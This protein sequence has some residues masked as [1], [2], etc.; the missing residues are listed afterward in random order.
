MSKVHGAQAWPQSY[1][2]RR[3]VMVCSTP[4]IVIKQIT[5]SH[6]SF[7]NTCTIEVTHRPI[8]NQRP[9]ARPISLLRAKSRASLLIYLSTSSSPMPTRTSRSIPLETGEASAGPTLVWHYMEPLQPQLRRVR[10][11]ARAA[12]EHN[13]AAELGLARKSTRKRIE[14]KWTR[15]EREGIVFKVARDA[16]GRTIDAERGG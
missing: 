14:L 10:E 8:Y 13:S 6:S 11:K 16:E 7:L 15:D 5:P 2:V 4:H 1:S 3:V 12:K 9:A